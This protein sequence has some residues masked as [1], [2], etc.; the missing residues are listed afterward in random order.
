M[1]KS[2]AQD[3]YAHTVTAKRRGDL[4]PE[5]QRQIDAV[6]AGESN[7]VKLDGY[8]LPGAVEVP[9]QIRQLTTLQSLSIEGMRIAAL[10]PWLADLPDLR[11]ID[12]SSSTVS[13]I[14]GSLP[15]VDWGL[16]ADQYHAFAD[17]IDPGKIIELTIRQQST[18]PALRQAFGLGKDGETGLSSLMIGGPMPAGQTPR[19]IQRR[20]R[21]YAL[22]DSKLDGFL[23]RQQGLRELT[24]FGCPIG[25]I[26]APIR[27]LQELTSITLGGIWPNAIPEWLFVKQGLTFLDLRY[28]DLSNLPGTLGD[29]MYLEYLYLDHNNFRH[30]PE[31]VWKLEGLKE[32]GISNCPIEDIPADI[33]RLPRLASLELKSGDGVPKSL[34]IP[35]PEIATKGLDAIKRVLV[36]AGAWCERGLPSRSQVVDRGRTRGGQD[37]AGEEDSRS[38]LRTGCH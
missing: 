8:F 22:I 27:Q 35:P 26:P 18:G 7:E 38:G 31:A 16:D 30:I 3:V 37:V 17:Q 32:L 34:L 28:N 9:Q 19:E 2:S 1:P 4:P 23:A 33:L 13:A 5:I 24:I 11:F 12:I 6:L 29:A 15:N 21:C 20:W 36:A 14:P 10:P 25:R